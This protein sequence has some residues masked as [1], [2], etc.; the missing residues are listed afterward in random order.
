MSWEK[1]YEM[2]EKLV[3]FSRIF[4]ENHIRAMLF[5]HEIL[6]TVV[7][8]NISRNVRGIHLN[9]FPPTSEMIMKLVVGSFFPS[10]LG[11]SDWEYK[12]N[13]PLKKFFLRALAAT[14]YMHLQATKPDTVGTYIHLHAST[15]HKT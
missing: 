5:D 7:L 9:F 8:F 14:G 1:V 12:L 15:G 13:Y 10:L 3:K 2:L 11:I 4:R 6:S